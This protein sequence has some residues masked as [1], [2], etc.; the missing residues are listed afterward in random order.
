LLQPQGR[1]SN[2]NKTTAKTT[3]QTKPE[4]FFITFPFFKIS[5]AGYSSLTTAFVPV[6]RYIYSLSSTK[7]TAIYQVIIAAAD[8]AVNSNRLKNAS[9]LVREYLIKTKFT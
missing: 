3:L 1:I 7:S 4:V 9:S 6:S 5:Q 2:A 8:P